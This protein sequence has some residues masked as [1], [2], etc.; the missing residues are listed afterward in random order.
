MAT[1]PILVRRF[2]KTAGADADF[3]TTQVAPAAALLFDV[4][5]LSTVEITFVAYDAA[6]A[7]STGTLD[8]QAVFVDP[9]PLRAGVASPAAP[10]VLVNGPVVSTS[11]SIGRPVSFSV[12]NHAQMCVRVA[13]TAGL[14]VG[15]DFCL[16]YVRPVA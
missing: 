1:A 12:A 3:I 7:V 13:N 8:I 16:I 9:L 14:A 10:T 2:V 11:V 6:G 5:S 15:V 4:G